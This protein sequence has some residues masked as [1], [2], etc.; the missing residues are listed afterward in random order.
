M[1]LGMTQPWSRP[2]PVAS[3]SVTP[4]DAGTSPAPSKR[5]RRGGGGR[6]SSGGADPVDDVGEPAVVLTDADRRLEWRGDEVALPSKRVDMAGGGDGRALE[7]REIQMTI[8]RDGQ[9]MLDCIVRAVGE[10]PL[11]STVTLEMLVDGTGRVLKSRVQ[12]P[13]YLFAHG[14]LPCAKRAAQQLGFPATGAHTVVTQPF[15]LY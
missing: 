10:A 3:A 1:Y 5:K 15:E 13:V 14:L 7:G 2:D 8:S 12:A 11:E 6:A 4:I 9:A